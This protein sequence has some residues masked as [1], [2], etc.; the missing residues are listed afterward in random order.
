MNVFN[1]YSKYYDL[2]Y[3]DKDYSGETLYIKNLLNEFGL[4]ASSILEF[5]SGTGKHGRLLGKFGHHVTGVELSGEM[6]GAAKSTDNFTCI[7]GDMTTVNLNKTFDCVLSLFHVV[8]Y[9]TKDSQI[10]EFFKN[11]NKHLK[12]GGLLIFDTWYSPSVNSNLPEVRVK[13]MKDSDIEIIRI[14]E[15]DIF[16]NINIVDVKY[17][18]FSRRINELSW[19]LIDEV[20]SMRHFSIPEIENFANQN[21]FDLLRSEEFKTKNLPSSDTWGVCYVLRK[22]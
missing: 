5:G 20:H 22:S 14:A 11:A 19:S 17:S 3:A 12:S 6:V 9:L 2:L 4:E 21:G 1:L 10:T 16:P 8:S 7:Q 13:R 18:I 15:P